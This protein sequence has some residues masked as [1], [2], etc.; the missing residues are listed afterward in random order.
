MNC[1]ELDYLLD[2][3]QGSELRLSQRQAVDAHLQ[4][5]SECA[6]AWAT[7][8]ELAAGAVPSMPGTLRHRVAR[9]V[10]ARLPPRSGPTRKA[11][12]G[13]GLLVVGA[14]A[15]AIALWDGDGDASIDDTAG[16]PTAAI[17]PS[18]PQSPEAEASMANVPVDGAIG[19]E[20]AVAP[21]GVS[22]QASDYAL[23]PR[24]LV[25]VIDDSNGD[26]AARATLADCHRRIVERL[27]ALPGL[28]VI[29]GEQVSSFA[30]SG[31]GNEA[32]ARE[33]G[34]GAFLLLENRFICQA[35]LFDARTG[36]FLAGQIADFTIGDES[37]AD[38]VDWDYFLGRVARHVN[39]KLLADEAALMAEAQATFLDTTLSAGD[40]LAALSRTTVGNSYVNPDIFN[41]AV[42]A[43]LS[44]IMTV[45]Q[46]A[47][48][49]RSAILNVRRLTDLSL[50]DPLL[51]VLVYDSEPQVRAVAASALHTFVSES[52]VRDALSQLATA[53]PSGDAAGICCEFT[54]A[55]AARRALLSDEEL[56][57]ATMA[58]LKNTA[59]TD[60]DRLY[61]LVSSLDGRGGAYALDEEH[62][63]IVFDVGSGSQNPDA[64]AYAWSALS[65]G[66][67]TS[68]DF[69]PTLLQDLAE[70]ADDG[71]RQ[72]AARALTDYADD[73]IVRARFEQVLAG[74]PCEC[75][76]ATLNQA[77]AER[78]R[79]DR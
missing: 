11:L 46:D 43:G 4:S 67:F 79:S 29:A 63:R 6:S 23:D 25:I 48:A 52:R 62:A 35:G 31:L 22:T 20:P 44:Q 56:R 41:V 5:C 73:P 18:S 38:D 2:S 65:Y 40:R 69:V 3:I 59:R 24:S 68:P 66:G 76:R 1:Q 53:D 55:E 57:A 47:E 34:A 13:C 16:A 71:V 37:D 72:S 54:V 39:D 77:L 42:I 49:R 36:D 75:V 8:S 28:N 21:D 45:A 15:A 51:Y 70:N 50:V 9:I 74:D 10:A 17:V 14:A 7:Y 58:H 61:P 33:L 27:D 26:P 30:G 12:I 78:T 64:R 60:Y 19:V 32:I